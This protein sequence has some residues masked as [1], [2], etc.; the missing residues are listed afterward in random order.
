MGEYRHILNDFK[1]VM[2]NASSYRTLSIL[3]LSLGT[4]GMMEKKKEIQSIR[5]YHER[6]LLVSNCD[7]THCI[8]LHWRVS[9]CNRSFGASVTT[10]KECD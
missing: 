9:D 5:P 4:S 10:N 2:C 6:S 3:N 1:I 8:N 7:T